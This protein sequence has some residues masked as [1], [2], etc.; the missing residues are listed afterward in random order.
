LKNLPGVIGQ[1]REPLPR[2]DPLTETGIAAD[3][4]SARGSVER[5]GA[6]RDALVYGIGDVHGMNDLL[7]SLLAAIEAD[8]AGRGLPATVVFLGDVV[9]R[10]AQTRQVLDRLVAGPT[11]PGDR[12]IVL[13]GNHEQVML[14]ALTA[15]SLVT[16][17]RWMKMG[18][19][20]T[21]ASYGCD[22]RK[23]TPDRARASIDPSHLRFLAELPVMHIAGDYLF[24][25]AGVEPGVPLQRQYARKLLTIRGRF[26]RK[27][28]GLPFTVVH[29]HTPTDGLPRLGPGR[30]GV[31]TGAYF[32]GILTAVAIEPNGDGWRFLSVTAPHAAARRRSADG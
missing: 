11:R 28:H 10:G 17:R 12:W 5:S 4:R 29:G 16:F 18:G 7:A 1:S 23:A 31:D 6:D 20:Q 24:V 27:P 21:L 30:I 14:D 25:H 22:R 32:T 19:V 15:A 3:G 9:N 26:L 2:L 13:R 8:A